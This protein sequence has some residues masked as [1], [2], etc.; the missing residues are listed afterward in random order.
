MK[1]P[2]L[3]YR[4][5]GYGHQHSRIAEIG[6]FK[7]I[8]ILVLG[9]SPAY[10]E[11]D[12]RVFEKYGFHT[13]NLGSSSQTPVQSQLLLSRYLSSL[14]PN[15]IIYIID[16]RLF[17]SDGVESAND[18]ISNDANDILSL[19]M[20][21]KLNHIK[22]YNALIYGSMRELLNL[23]A[24]FRQPIRVKYRNGIDTY[25]SGG[26]V[27]KN[28]NHYFN[29][30]DKELVEKDIVFIQ[31]QLEAFNKIISDL[32]NRG[33]D[34]ILIQPPIPNIIYKRYKN[35]GELDSIMQSY[36]RY[37]DFSKKLNLKDSCFYDASHL[38]QECAE[39]FSAKVAELIDSLGIIGKR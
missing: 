27:E 13:F 34:Y 8:D 5:G 37:Y 28:T 3:N 23:N 20:A 38:R 7:D 24:N 10:R 22:V 15:L 18:I 9:A 39:I 29:P 2:N 14:N 16:Q 11:L 32:K 26:Y 36:G 35:M 25:I 1:L 30:I 6:E 33:I 21:L 19:R 31:Y 4:L 12:V 17:S